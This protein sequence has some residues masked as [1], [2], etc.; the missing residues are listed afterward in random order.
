MK[1][2]VVRENRARSMAYSNEG[3]AVLVIALLVMVVLS[4]LGATFLTMATTESRIASNEE[5]TRQAFYAADAGI[6]EALARMN[7]DPTNVSDE[8]D[9][10]YSSTADPDA[11]R[12]PAII[13]NQN[14]NPDPRSTTS[15]VFWH[16]N[17]SWSHTGPN[18][19]GEGNYYG[20][21]PSQRNNLDSAGRAFNS[22]QNSGSR[23]LPTGSSYSVQVVPI[24]KKVSGSWQFVDYYG[25]TLNPPYYI[26]YKVTSTGSS[27]NAQ[28]TIQVAVRKYYIRNAVPAPLATGGSVKV[29]GNATIDMGDNPT[30]VAIQS[31]STIEK[32]GSAVING[33]QVQGT[34]F[35]GF[36]KVFGMSKEEMESKSLSSPN[37]HLEPTGDLTNP[38]PSQT[39]P[40]LPTRIIWIS[41]PLIKTTFSANWVIGSAANPVILVTEGDL[42]FN[43]VTVYGIV[44][45][46]GSFR[47]QGK[48]NLTGGVLVEGTTET[49]I[50]GTGE[51]SKLLYSQS[52]VNKLNNSN[53]FPFAVVK[54]SWHEY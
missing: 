11:V 45:V 52:T 7:L 36:E 27:G 48:S 49:D 21:R 32:T 51:G 17:P 34:P 1:K 38:F 35:P 53:L 14:P 29:G 10:P 46:M 12:D 30:G 6:Q 4:L 24:V 43:S 15:P 39:D 13:N 28:K 18:A 31:A 41:N 23:A 42:T 3:G 47:N 25:N 2:G 8:V 19:D 33:T 26:Y 22:S 54:G 16:Y 9:T 20:A 40:N 44:Y 37:L 5:E 50:L